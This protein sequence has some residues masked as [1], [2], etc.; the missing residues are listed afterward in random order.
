MDVDGQEVCLEFTGLHSNTWLDPESGH[1]FEPARSNAVVEKDIKGRDL[2]VYRSLPV[3][4]GS[5]SAH[6]VSKKHPAEQVERL[7]LPKSSLGLSHTQN[8]PIREV[9]G[10][11]HQLRLPPESP[12]SI[13]IPPAP[14]KTSMETQVQPVALHGGDPSTLSVL[15]PLGHHKPSP[16]GPARRPKPFNV[17]FCMRCTTI[18]TSIP[19]LGTASRQP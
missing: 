14:Q 3:P 12:S 5:H 7:S 11:C 19:S 17:A 9:V 16:S 13:L 4:N 6:V 10:S 15:R 1:L 8:A 2:R 18:C